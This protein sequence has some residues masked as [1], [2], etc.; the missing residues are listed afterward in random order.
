[1]CGILVSITVRNYCSKR[2]QKKNA[3][4]INEKMF[5]VMNDEVECIADD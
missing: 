4:I 2:E 5:D 3:E 1:M